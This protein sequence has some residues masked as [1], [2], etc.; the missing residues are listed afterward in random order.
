M[1]KMT[2]PAAFCEADGCVL[3]A[4]EPGDLH[5]GVW[6]EGDGWE[7]A[8]VQSPG[9]PWEVDVTVP[10]ETLS[11]VE[12]RALAAALSSAASDERLEP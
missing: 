2:H 7:V 5:R 9:G 3:L 4:H 1:D 8:A 12:A 10:G 11:A 6:F